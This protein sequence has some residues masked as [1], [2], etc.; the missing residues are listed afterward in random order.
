MRTLTPN[1]LGLH[2]DAQT[3]CLHYHG[4]TDI[5]AI[6]MKCCGLFYACKDCHIAL[7]DHPIAVWPESEWH[8]EAILCGACRATL[9]ISAYLHSN[10]RCPACHAHFNPACRNHHHFYFTGAPS[11][12]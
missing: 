1:V 10:S 6:Q 2:L 4:P 5:V 9:T 12:L 11:P 3:R 7:A 8:H